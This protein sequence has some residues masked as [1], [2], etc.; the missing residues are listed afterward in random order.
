MKPSM[1]VVVVGLVVA[2]GIARA[3]G[4]GKPVEDRLAAIEA[5][6]ARVEA[7]LD[8]VGTAAP[9]RQ[10]GTTPAALTAAQRAALVAVAKKLESYMLGR[11]TLAEAQRSIFD[12]LTPEEIVALQDLDAG[13]AKG[14][15]GVTWSDLRTSIG[16]IAAR[17]VSLWL[18]EPDWMST[19]KPLFSA[20]VLYRLAL[21]KGDLAGLKAAYE[22]WEKAGGGK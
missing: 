19:R 9:A 4:D 16:I 7:R 5:R 21:E 6:L 18:K 20:V 2:A 12:A 8:S 11:G 17:L 22:A 14:D 15:F 3:G 1:I 13:L 10:P